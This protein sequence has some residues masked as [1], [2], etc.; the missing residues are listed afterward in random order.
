MIQHVKPLAYAIMIILFLFVSYISKADFPL[1][2]KAVS[3]MLPLFIVLT[4]A[5][6]EFMRIQEEWKRKYGK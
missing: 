3:L 6:S 5:V 4:L 2:E 1:L